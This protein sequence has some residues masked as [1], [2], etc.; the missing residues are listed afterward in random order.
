MR[1]F[2]FVYINSLDSCAYFTIE[3]L[4]SNAK[5]LPVI[6]E[7]YLHFLKFIVEKADSPTQEVTNILKC[8]PITELTVRF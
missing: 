1:Y 6:F 3:H 2:T 8:F 4:I 7:L 5:F